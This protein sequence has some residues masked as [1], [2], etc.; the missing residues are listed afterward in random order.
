MVLAVVLLAADVFFFKSEDCLQ[1]NV[2]V[3]NNATGKLPVAVFLPG[4]NFRQGAASTLLYDSRYWVAATPFVMV[5]V[6]YRLGALGWLVQD[7][8]PRNLGIQDQ[9]L[10]LQWVADN[11][12]AFG[13][14]AEQ[15][16]LMGQSAGGT[17]IGYHLLSNKSGGLFHRVVSESNPLGLPLKNPEDGRRFGDVF[18]KHLKCGRGDVACLRKAAVPDIVAAQDAT[19]KH[20]SVTDPLLVRP[21]LLFLFCSCLRC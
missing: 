15:V 1:L 16:T 19:N 5:T 20:F 2:F 18:M 7:G 14:D 12:G 6:N 9:R 4:G 17:S 11:I 10:A 13:G 3:P 8:L 21:F